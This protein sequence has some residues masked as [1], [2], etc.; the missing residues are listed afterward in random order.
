MEMLQTTD[1]RAA[2]AAV[3][4]E[5]QAVEPARRVRERERGA[6]ARLDELVLEELIY[7]R[8]RASVDLVELLLFEQ[9]LEASISRALSACAAGP[10]DRRRLAARYIEVAWRRVEADLL[11]RLVGDC[12]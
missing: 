1:L 7:E 6:A 2:G 12:D 10:D 5:P 8:V 11:D 4:P 3:E 9:D